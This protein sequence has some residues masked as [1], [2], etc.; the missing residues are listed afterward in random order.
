MIPMRGEQR[1]FFVLSCFLL[2][3]GRTGQKSK[4]RPAVQGTCPL[5]ITRHENFVL[6][7]FHFD[8]EQTRLR[9][10]LS[11]AEENTAYHLSQS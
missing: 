11:L 1:R 4:L 2:P 8:D 6:F 10:Q 9:Q 3:G 5:L 7:F